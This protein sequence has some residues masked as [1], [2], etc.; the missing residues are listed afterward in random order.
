MERECAG[1][2]IEDEELELLAIDGEVPEVVPVV[3]KEIRI[4][5]LR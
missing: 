2:R 3:S 5:T 4:G 1:L